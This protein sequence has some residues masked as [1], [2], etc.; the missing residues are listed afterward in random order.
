[1]VNIKQGLIL[2][3]V[4]L[5][6]LGGFTPS[7]C[8]SNVVYAEM[9]TKSSYDSNNLEVK[10]S[11]YISDDTAFSVFTQIAKE[12][13]NQVGLEVLGYDTSKK[14]IYFDNS[15]YKSM[16]VGDRKEFIKHVL[17]SIKDSNLSPKGKNKLYNFITSQDSDSAKILRN[18]ESDVTADIASGKEWYEPFNGPVTTIFGLVALGVFIGMGLSIVLDISYLVL[19][20]VRSMVDSN[21]EGR[22]PRLVSPQAYF[23]AQ[24]V[25]TMGR[26][27]YMWDYF[28]RRSWSVALVLIALGYLNSGLIFEVI[29]NFMQVFSDAFRE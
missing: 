13:N 22:I 7:F 2:G 14:V 20:M 5:S 24:D 25:D 16:Y 19:P 11:A 9:Q 15:L 1:M 10:S 28:R 21:P 27:S 17:N 8:S 3:G 4:M 23:T 26:G 18:L 12:S 6:M 29:G